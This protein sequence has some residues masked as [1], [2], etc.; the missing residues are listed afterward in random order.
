MEE[1]MGNQSD[2]WKECD[3]N[4]LY[5]YT[6][7]CAAVSI[8]QSGS[9]RFTSIKNSNDPKEA[10]PALQKNCKFSDEENK[11]FYSQFIDYYENDIRYMSCTVD[12]SEDLFRNKKMKHYFCGKG[13]NRSRMWAQYA[14]NSTGV[15]ICFNK[16]K[17]EERVKK[18]YGE[19]KIN[20]K[21]IEYEPYIKPTK[22]VELKDELGEINYVEH[23]YMIREEDIKNDKLNAEET[24]REHCEDNFFKK[25]DDWRDEREHRIICFC[26]KESPLEIGIDDIIEYIVLGYKCC[27]NCKKEIMTYCKKLNIPCKYIT[28]LNG[29]AQLRELEEISL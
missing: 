15:C 28:Y 5:H 6:N 7:A 19:D 27:D 29:N 21:K 10:Y 9:F 25:S 1:F 12:S 11:R 17:I 16:T 24:T 8:L 13:F 23:I 2:Q 26:N 20:S 18:Q 4:G 22:N 3:T 14:G